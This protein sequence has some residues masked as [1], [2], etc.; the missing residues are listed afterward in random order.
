MNFGPFLY[1]QPNN[2]KKHVQNIENLEKKTANARVA[3]VLNITCL[4]IYIEHPIQITNYLTNILITCYDYCE[5]KSIS[6][7]FIIQLM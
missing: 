5:S 1:L 3:I 6:H 7:A 4:N 2:I